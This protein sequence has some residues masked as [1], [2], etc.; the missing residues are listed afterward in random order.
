MSD[1]ITMPIEQTNEGAMAFLMGNGVTPADYEFWYLS[2]CGTEVHT[3]G[4]PQIAFKGQQDEVYFAEL[5]FK[6][7]GTLVKLISP[8]GTITP[9]PLIEGDGGRSPV[10][11]A[12]NVVRGVNSR[13]KTI[14]IITPMEWVRT[15]IDS[16]D[17]W[18]ANGWLNPSN[19][20]PKNLDLWKEIAK[21][22]KANGIVLYAAKSKEE[23]LKMTKPKP[24]KKV[25]AK[26]VKVSQVDSLAPFINDGLPPEWGEVSGGLNAI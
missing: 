13:V 6:E 10:E 11:A 2:N 7:V 24:A 12:L 21:E 16:L 26:K 15:S 3:E 18:E 19:K 4:A 20:E 8:D 17:K 23:V 14:G 9:L 1:K 5:A 25:I 22:L